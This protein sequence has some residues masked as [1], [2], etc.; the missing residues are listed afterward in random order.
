MTL[1]QLV[2]QAT[3]S[4]LTSTE[5]DYER[6]ISEV[7]QPEGYGLLSDRLMPGLSLGRV[8]K[9]DLVK[10]LQLAST[11]KPEFV[12]QCKDE[13]VNLNRKLQGTGQ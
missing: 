4:L 9:Q 7:A 3:S 5:Q 2:M 11:L 8:P 10:L 12:A 13:L 1:S 6:V